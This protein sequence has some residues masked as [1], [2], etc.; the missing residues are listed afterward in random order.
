M[1]YFLKIIDSTFAIA[2]KV[3]KS[4]DLRFFD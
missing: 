3:A 1:E 2:A 4:L